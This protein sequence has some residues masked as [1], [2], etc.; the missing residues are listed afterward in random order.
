MKQVIIV[1]D[2][3]DISDPIRV[4][5]AMMTRWKPDKDT[6]ILTRQKGSSLDPSRDEDGLTS[7]VGFD[8]TIPVGAD[9]SDFT[10]VLR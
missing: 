4:E 3:I 6:V 5:W 8:A 7:K 10:T 9:R 1:D 2:D